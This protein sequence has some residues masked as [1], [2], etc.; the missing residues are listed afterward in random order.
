MILVDLFVQWNNLGYKTEEGEQRVEEDGGRRR[1]LIQK[2]EFQLDFREINISSNL[3]KIKISMLNL[4]S[5][6]LFNIKNR[7]SEYKVKI[8]HLNN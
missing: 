8:N 7:R 6:A 5:T 4:S 1:F 3:G 2:F